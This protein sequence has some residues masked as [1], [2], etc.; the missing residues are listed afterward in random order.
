[1]IKLK[2]ENQVTSIVNNVVAACKDITKLNKTG[3]DYIYLASGFIAHY[4]L[5]GFIAHYSENSL[6]LDIVR[7]IC[8]NRYSNFRPGDRDF[9]YYN[10]KAD[11]YRRIA[12]E[13]Q[14]IRDM[15]ESH[16]RAHYDME[17]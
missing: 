12:D 1:M 3:Y 16:E 7:N 8:M 14:K 13:L 4:N 15:D 17:I 5:H 10:Q 11:I 9:D 6:E 2:T